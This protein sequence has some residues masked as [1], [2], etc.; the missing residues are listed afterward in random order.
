MDV[1][2]T[3]GS[4][5]F[6]GLDKRYFLR[7][8][9]H[10]HTSSSKKILD[11]ILNPASSIRKGHARKKTSGIPPSRIIFEEGDENL[12]IGGTFNKIVSSYR[13][14]S[15]DNLVLLEFF[16]YYQVLKVTSDV[17]VVAF[18][19]M[20]EG[21]LPP[22]CV[23]SDE[24]RK[25]VDKKYSFLEGWEEMGN[26]QLREQP[27]D[28]TEVILNEVIEVNASRMRYVKS[29][30]VETTDIIVKLRDKFYKGEE[31]DKAENANFV[32]NV[33]PNASPLT[34]EEK[35]NIEKCKQTL[36]L[37]E[38][39][40][41]WKRMPGS[42]NDQ[43]EKFKRTTSDNRIVV[44]G[45]VQIDENA[46]TIVADLTLFTSNERNRAHVEWNG[47]SERSWSYMGM[48]HTCRSTAEVK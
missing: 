47:N 28:Q 35:S 41:E 7:C 25:G 2:S 39:N 6:E 19:T 34:D 11:E 42:V 48:S 16:H 21:M 45:R 31:V 17:T 40:L 20:K 46:A 15:S 26:F 1:N 43:V 27:F 37:G 33:I 29:Y 13:V 38:E 5:V 23:P 4:Q 32:E 24:Y 44:K 9:A 30:L 8:H 14:Y 18:C 3:G 10:V 22:S 12:E 36:G